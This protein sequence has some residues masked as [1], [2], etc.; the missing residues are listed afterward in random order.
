MTSY[1][2]C[3]SP[4][5]YKMCHKMLHDLG[6]PDQMMKY[7]TI[8]A[9]SVDGIPKGFISTHPGRILFIGKLI[10]DKKIP[11]PAFVIMRLFQS[12]EYLLAYKGIK[13][14]FIPVANSR[15]VII[16]YLKEL[17]IEEYKNDRDPRNKWFRR[18]VNGRRPGSASTVRI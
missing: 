10:V 7:P 3:K 5:D 18:I 16:D 1:K 8:V 13:E 14:Y 11:N 15:D 9:L 17:G 4:Q 12:Y 2:V 6:E